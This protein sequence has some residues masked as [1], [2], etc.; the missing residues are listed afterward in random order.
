MKQ[1]KNVNFMIWL[2]LLSYLDNYLIIF[3]LFSD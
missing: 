3:Y 1:V 2:K